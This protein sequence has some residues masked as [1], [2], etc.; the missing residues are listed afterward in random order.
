MALDIATRSVQSP[1]E[2][3][4]TLRANEAEGRDGMEWWSG[5]FQVESWASA[6]DGFSGSEPGC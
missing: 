3:K 6:K 2:D 4:W 1:A 5:A